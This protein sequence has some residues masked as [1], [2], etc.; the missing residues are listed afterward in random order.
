MSEKKE[1]F[2][3]KCKICGWIYDPKEGESLN[4][5]EPNTPFEDVREDFVCPICAFGKDRFVKIE[6]FQL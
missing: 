2:R 6:K 5:V 1:L 4:H 3:Y